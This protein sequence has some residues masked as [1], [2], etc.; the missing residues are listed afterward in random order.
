MLAGVYLI[1]TVLPHQ[2]LLCRQRSVHGHLHDRRLHQDPRSWFYTRRL[3]LPARRLELA[4]LP[5]SLASVRPAAWTTV[6]RF[7]YSWWK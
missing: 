3:S 7:C 1:V 5:R 6:M 4:R 2:R